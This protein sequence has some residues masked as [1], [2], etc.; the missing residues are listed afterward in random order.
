MTDLG[1]TLEDFGNDSK[2]FDKKAQIVDDFFKEFHEA[3]A[4]G[5]TVILS[6]F[7]KE[8]PLIKNSDPKRTAELNASLTELKDT[9]KS[10]ESIKPENAPD[11]KDFTA[12][13]LFAIDA[14]KKP[15]L[16]LRDGTFKDVDEVVISVVE[17]YKAWKEEEGN[18]DLGHKAF[19][20]SSSSPIE[21]GKRSNASTVLGIKVGNG[22]VDLNRKYF[23]ESLK[24]PLTSL[25]ESYDKM[26]NLDITPVILT[27][28]QN[29]AVTTSTAV[30]S[31]EASKPV[32]L[33]KPPE[34]LAELKKFDI[35]GAETE[36]VLSKIK[37]SESTDLLPAMAAKVSGLIRKI[38]KVGEVDK[39]IEEVSKT[40]G[41][42]LGSLGAVGK[43]VSLVLES[44][45]ED[46][47]EKLTNSESKNEGTGSAI[48]N[49]VI[50]K[51][52]EALDKISEKALGEINKK[53]SGGADKV[54]ET[55]S[56]AI[57]DKIDE[58]STG[59]KSDKKTEAVSPNDRA[60]KIEKSKN[61][62]QEYSEYYEAKK[63]SC[64]RITTSDLKDAIPLSDGE[65]ASKKI[66]ALLNNFVSI[67]REQVMSGA[68]KPDLDT[69][70][71]ANSPV[72]GK[73]ELVAGWVKDLAESYSQ[74][75]L[76]EA[77]SKK[78]VAEESMVKNSATKE[79]LLQL[80]TPK[81]FG[82]NNT[83]YEN[84]E[85]TVGKF[86]EEFKSAKEKDQKLDL[87]KFFKDN[88]F[89][90]D[91]GAAKTNLFGTRVPN[92]A[93]E[94][95]DVIVKA[96]QVVVD[97]PAVLTKG[98]EVDALSRVSAPIKPASQSKPETNL[99]EDS[100]NSARVVKEILHEHDVVVGTKS[101]TSNNA[102]IP[103]VNKTEHSSGRTA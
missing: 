6:K 93:R 14:L 75:R 21:N 4:R 98:K 40:T 99:N 1:L 73:N 81:D 78:T 31:L 10:A 67:Y 59:I 45:R 18:K 34:E 57:A 11:Q 9:S 62:A 77:I 96:L 68:T 58:L 37:T 43:S 49:R 74:M 48:L 29:Q 84:R 65:S 50:D 100:K 69:F 27:N 2:K 22:E 25:L 16:I 66:N 76:A 23:N 20:K 51:G 41:V 64:E 97:A 92:P 36:S 39:V 12:K 38:S 56:S 61:D 47:L 85:D 70:V 17:S 28:R 42:E 95:F 13:K 101:K 3:E 26:A 55:A 32:K 86:L 79:S 24:Q 89:I 63:K 7:L 72:N 87:R 80:L 82:N 19:F 83:N 71:S 91:T 103:I 33:E 35:Q 46:G 53:V 54:I 44:S 30:S 8:N 88:P 94:R 5:Q 60:D 102:V 15:G 90:A 52:A